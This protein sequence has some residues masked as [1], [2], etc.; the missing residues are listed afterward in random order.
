MATPPPFTSE[1]SI[2]NPGNLCVVALFGKLD[3][4]AAE[5]F[6][7]QLDGLRQQGHTRFVLDFAGLEYVGSLGLRVFVALHNAL[8]ASGFLC[9]CNISASIRSIFTIT[10][11]DKIL[12]AYPT[13]ADAIDAIRSW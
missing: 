2:A 1:V 6:Q 4:L 12:R 5:D 3:A 9:C 7:T 8:Q 10:K 13:R 11:L